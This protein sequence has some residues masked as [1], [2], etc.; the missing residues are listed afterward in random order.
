V[1]F[2]L[3]LTVRPA[4]IT[5]PPTGLCNSEVN[6]RSDVEPWDLRAG[7]L[8]KLGRRE[9]HDRHRADRDPGQWNALHPSPGRRTR[10]A[11][12]SYRA[13]D[14]VDIAQPRDRS[15]NHRVLGHTGSLEVG[16][17]VLEVVLELPDQAAA[18]QPPAAH[19]AR[20]P[21]QELWDRR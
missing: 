14:R 5:L 17:A 15:A 8:G 9:G 4:L 18:L 13:D 19:R 1:K 21:G 16:H 6:D 20:H 12:G 7:C 11:G 10:R 3:G 2:A